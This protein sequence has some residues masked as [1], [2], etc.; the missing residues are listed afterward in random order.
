M[1]NTV[2]GWHQRWGSLI[3]RA[4]V[5]IYTIIDEMRK[6]QHQTELQIESIICG[7]ERPRQLYSV[8]GNRGR[9]GSEIVFFNKIDLYISADNPDIND[10]LL[11]RTNV[12]IF[13]YQMIK[14]NF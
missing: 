9:S 14:N 10:L 5:G 12:R 13:E 4:H 1:Q 6:E 2:E 11:F 8:S 7:E 3:G